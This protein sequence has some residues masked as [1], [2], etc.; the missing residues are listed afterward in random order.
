MDTLHLNTMNAEK[1]KRGR[2]AESLFGSSLP[3]V[4]NDILRALRQGV[5]KR[6]EKDRHAERGPAQAKCPVPGMREEKNDGE[7]RSNDMSTIKL[8]P[9]YRED[10]KAS[11]P[12]EWE[13]WKDG[14]RIYAGTYRQ[15]WAFIRKRF[16]GRE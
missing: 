7:V 1:R 14:R 2:Y 10:D 13:V 8:K 6:D 16:M 15:C 12:W 3:G 5:W 9:V 11:V 4:R